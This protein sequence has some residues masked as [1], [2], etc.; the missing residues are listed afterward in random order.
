LSN[1]PSH[2]QPPGRSG[3]DLPTYRSRTQENTRYLRDG[4]SPALTRAIKSEDRLPRAGTFAYCQEE[5]YRV[6][7]SDSFRREREL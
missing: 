2:P 3:R 5:I 7:L 4:C 1:P 6:V